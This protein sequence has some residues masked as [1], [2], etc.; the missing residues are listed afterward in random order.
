M[1]ALNLDGAYTRAVVS[2]VEW[3]RHVHP[4]VLT[5]MGLG[6]DFVVLYAV[7]EQSALLLAASMFIRYSCDCLDGAVARQYGKV[8]DLG[9]ILDTLADNTFIFIVSGSIAQLSNMPA[10]W[11]IALVITGVNIAYLWK[12]D[13]LVH[14]ATVKDGGDVVRDTYAFGVNN[15]ALLYP[16]AFFVLW[17]LM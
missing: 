14:H 12:E 6:M 15:N 13:A 2:R 3:L 4:N 9:G 11:M 1:K 16:A 10:P 7:L 8:S 5:L 17:G